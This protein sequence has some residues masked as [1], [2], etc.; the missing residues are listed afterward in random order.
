M[1]THGLDVVHLERVVTFLQRSWSRKVAVDVNTFLHPHLRNW[2]WKLFSG[3]IIIIV[4]IIIIIIIIFII[5]II[6]I[7]D[8]LA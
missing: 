4:I 5:I 1:D 2:S 7:K 6:I 8:I 3:I